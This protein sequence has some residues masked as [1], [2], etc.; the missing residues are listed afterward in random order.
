MDHTIET[1][2]VYYPC[3][4]T[5][6]KGI[7][8]PRLPSYKRGIEFKDYKINQLTL[9]EMVDSS[10]ENYGMKGSPTQVE[11]VSTAKKHR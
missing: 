9:N 11:N 6:D 4:I 2:E 5:V 1:W 8:T 10:E 7:Y 3:L